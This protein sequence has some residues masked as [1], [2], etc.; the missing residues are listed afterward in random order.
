MKQLILSLVIGVAAIGLVLPQQANAV[1]TLRVSDGIEAHTI[2]LENGAA[3]DGHPKPEVVLFTDII[4]TWTINVT[5][6]IA[7][8]EG[9][10]FMDLNSINVSTTGPSS[11]HIEFSQTG[12]TTYN[13]SWEARIGGTAADTIQYSTYLGTSNNLFE[14]STLLTNAGPLGGAFANTTTNP[15]IVIA[16]PYS[17]TQSVQFTHP[18]SGSTSFNAELR[19]V[20]EP[21]ALLLMGLGFLGLAL[22]QRREARS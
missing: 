1:P 9:R 11:L 5:T 14:Q 21:S 7:L 16:N 19:S 15:G 13:G 22:W 20:P 12:F 3:A 8:T 10:P 6:G 4:G 18:G 2:V 17:L